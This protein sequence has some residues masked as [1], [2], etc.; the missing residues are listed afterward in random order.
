MTAARLGCTEYRRACLAQQVISGSPL[1]HPAAEVVRRRDHAVAGGETADLR[2]GSDP[3]EAGDGRRTVHARKDS[4]VV[5]SSDS[6]VRSPVAEEVVA[7]GRD[8]RAPRRTLVGPRQGV[9]G[10]RLVAH[11][12]VVDVD[13]L[14]GP[15]PYGR[16]TD[17]VPSFRTPLPG[18]IDERHLVARGHG[19]AGTR[20][21]R[22][23]ASTT[24]PAARSCI[25]IPTSSTRSS[26]TRTV[27]ASAVPREGPRL[28]QFR[29]RPSA[30]ANHSRQ[31]WLGATP[32]KPEG[33]TRY[34]ASCPRQRS[35]LTSSS[36]R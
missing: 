30:R 5:P 16:F 35:V 12:K 6:P 21:A 23:L 8:R 28:R 26:G 4:D 36:M 15:D 34:H 24:S 17:R 19:G 31:R 7:G 27:G 11:A 25:A 14:T 18:E 29:C 32:S 2:V 9:R 1:R 10:A 33:R 13:V 20:K 22:P 3:S